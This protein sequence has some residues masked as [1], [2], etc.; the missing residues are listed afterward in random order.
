MVG[1]VIHDLVSFP[2]QLENLAV[3]AEQ[4]SVALQQVGVLHNSL[5]H[6]RHE[7]RVLVVEEVESDAHVLCEH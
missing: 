4:V 7:A 3:C 5:D 1:S 2:V 6:L